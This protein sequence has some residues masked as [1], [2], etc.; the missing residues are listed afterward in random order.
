[1]G[2][3]P[4]HRRYVD[5]KLHAAGDMAGRASGL[6]C[7]EK[8]QQSFTVKDERGRVYILPADAQAVHFSS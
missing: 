8:G 2:S 5:V 3:S 1:M 7:S 6:C 4:E